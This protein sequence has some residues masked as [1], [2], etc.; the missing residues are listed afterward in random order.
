M[1]LQNALFKNYS[2]FNKNLAYLVFQ[3]ILVIAKAFSHISFAVL[4]IDVRHSPLFPILYIAVH[5]FSYIALPSMY[6]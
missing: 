2:I 4:W 5:L 3:W 6:I 1:N